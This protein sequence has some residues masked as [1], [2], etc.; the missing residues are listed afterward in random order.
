MVTLQRIMLS[1]LTMCRCLSSCC[2]FH[3]K[4]DTFGEPIVCSKRREGE[5]RRVV[6]ADGDPAGKHVVIVDDLVQTGGTLIE[7]ARA[8]HDAGA[9]RVS[10]Y[11]THAVFPRESWRR[12]LRPTAAAAATGGDATAAAVAPTAAGGGGGGAASS[13]AA[14]GASGGFPGFEHFF[15]TNSCPNTAA[16]LAGQAPFEVLSITPVV[17]DILGL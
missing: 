11:V 8:L 7:C 15:I 2:R 13:S 14:P 5:A 9:A 3:G 4:L 17:E 10:A 6:I 16:A 1:L 12:F